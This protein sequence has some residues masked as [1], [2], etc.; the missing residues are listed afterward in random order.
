[1]TQRQ[2]DVIDRLI[3]VALDVL[4]HDT[5]DGDAVD[6]YEREVLQKKFSAVLKPNVVA[7]RC[8]WKSEPDWK[9]GEKPCSAKDLAR[10]EP[11]FVEQ[12]LTVSSQDRGTA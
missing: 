4:H 2:D 12:A 1:M 10:Q 9:Y 3:Q 5:D 7:W 6:K 8:R 11:G